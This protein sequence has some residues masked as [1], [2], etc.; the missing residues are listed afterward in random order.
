MHGSCRLPGADPSLNTDKAYMG[1]FLMDPLATLV[2]KDSF[3][4][5]LPV[6]Q[7]IVVQEEDIPVDS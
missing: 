4:K 1:R 5:D 6:R 7:H 2:H 3:L